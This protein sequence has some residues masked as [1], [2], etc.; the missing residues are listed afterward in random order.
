MRSAYLNDTLNKEIRLDR[1]FTWGCK[2]FEIDI[3]FYF[4][5]QA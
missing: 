2:K 3:K 4:I 5:P 1:K